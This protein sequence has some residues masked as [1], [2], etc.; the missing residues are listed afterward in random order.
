MLFML[1][2]SL[3]LPCANALPGKRAAAAVMADPLTATLRNSLLVLILVARP[4]AF[5][6]RWPQCELLGS[7]AVVVGAYF[8]PIRH[9]EYLQRGTYLLSNWNSRAHSN[10]AVTAGWN[11]LVC[12]NSPLQ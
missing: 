11:L 6:P 12:F 2:P 1:L 3:V 10:L 7:C 4:V 8:L 5:G 9:G